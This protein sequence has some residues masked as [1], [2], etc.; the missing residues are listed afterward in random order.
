MNYYYTWPN[1]AKQEIIISSLLVIIF[2]SGFKMH[3]IMSP[4]LFSGYRIVND[5]MVLK[6]FFESLVRSSL[7]ISEVISSKV[8]AS[9]SL[10][11]NLILLLDEILCLLGFFLI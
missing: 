6:E 9:G 8:F 10:E 4:S 5:L 3:F 2:P 11:Y 1:Y 7:S